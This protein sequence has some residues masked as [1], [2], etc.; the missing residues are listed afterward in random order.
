MMLGNSKLDKSVPIPLYFQLKE[1]ILAE[2]KNGNYKHDDVIP[3]ELE[4]SEMFQ[5]SR[6]TVRQAITELVQEEWLYRIK[7]KGTFVSKPKISQAFVQVLE[8]FDD[9]IIRS[10]KTPHTELLALKVI[11]VPESA[12]EALHLKLDDKV[13]FIHRRR[14]ADDEPI[15]ILKT[16]IPY[17]KC[18]FV[19]QHDMGKESLYTIL[20][21]HN[22]TE[23]YKIHRL[24]EAV[25]ATAHDAANL[26]IKKGSAIQKFTSTGYNMFGEPIEYSL[27][28]YR[29]DRNC[30]EV[31]V[32]PRTNYGKNS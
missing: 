3:T 30:F 32:A 25:E 26:N 19:M 17:T 16:Y 14:F 6:T 20:A 27:A 8:S 22:D 11:P 28:R 7:S 31:L 23:V 15:V 1:L 29:G 12:A 4:L 21:T 5:I 9:Q 18:S 10:G 2:I 24:I 13:I